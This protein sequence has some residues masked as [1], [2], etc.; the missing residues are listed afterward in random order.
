MELSGGLVGCGGV[1]GVVTTRSCRRTGVGVKV[2]RVGIGL[3][4]EV[5]DLLR[6]LVDVLR[7]LR[8]LEP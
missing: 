3:D 5:R 1:V 2:A 6:D 7:L 4:H 8:L